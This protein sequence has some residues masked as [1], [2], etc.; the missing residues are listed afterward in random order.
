MSFDC[1]CTINDYGELLSE[2]EEHKEANF[3]K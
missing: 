3:M 1:N 2:C